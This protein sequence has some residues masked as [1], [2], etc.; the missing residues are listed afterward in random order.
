MYIIYTYTHTDRDNNESYRHVFGIWKY[1]NS[2]YYV[3]VNAGYD[4]FE[5][6]NFFYQFLFYFYF[7][8]R[9]EKKERE[10]LSFFFFFL[11]LELY[12]RNMEMSLHM[13]RKMIRNRHLTPGFIVANHQFM[14]TFF[15]ILICLKKNNIHYS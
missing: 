10:F 11:F 14:N 12:N 7:F 5:Y 3:V 2:L 15:F 4:W 8:F 13:K 6:V 1:R 9:R